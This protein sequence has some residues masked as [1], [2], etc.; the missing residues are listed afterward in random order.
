MKNIVEY[1]SELDQVM[2]YLCWYVC[3][4]VYVLIYT[5]HGTFYACIDTLERHKMKTIVEHLS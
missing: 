3:M 5:K 2:S 4:Y 1:L